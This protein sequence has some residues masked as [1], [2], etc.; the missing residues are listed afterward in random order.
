M[1]EGV[2]G[3]ALFVFSGSRDAAVTEVF[4]RVGSIAA[5]TFAMILLGGVLVLDALASRL[6]RG[7]R[8]L[9]VV[10]FAFAASVMGVLAIASLTTYPGIGLLL[11]FGWVLTVPVG[12]EIRRASSFRNRENNFGEENR[13][14]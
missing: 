13:G 14:G 10:I 3:G 4:G 1:A 7:V 5:V 6:S 9:S 2:W 8:L 12:L 11:A